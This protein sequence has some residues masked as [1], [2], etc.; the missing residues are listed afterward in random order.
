MTMMWTMIWP[1]TLLKISLTDSPDAADIISKWILT[2]LASFQ[3]RFVVTDGAIL[4]L[5]KFL[6]ALL[7]VLGNFSSVIAKVSK[8]LP[9][10]VQS[11]C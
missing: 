10:S 6:A 8:A 4:W 7:A 3:S 2:L 11:R 1:I 5:L 9:R